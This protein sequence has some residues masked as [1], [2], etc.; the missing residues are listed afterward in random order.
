MSMVEEAL[1]KA[2]VSCES[3]GGRAPLRIRGPLRGGTYG[4]DGSKSSQFLTGL[5]IALARAPGDSVVRVDK[6]ASRGYVDL[7]LDIMRRFGA[8]ASRDD[9]YSRF[10]IAGESGYEGCAYEVEGDWSGGAFLLVAGALASGP[11]GMRVFGLSPG[12]ASPTAPYCKPWLW[13]ARIVL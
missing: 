12:R 9:E 5:L 4:L 8:T 10:S 1:L 3:S 13:Q 6:L 11:Q 7:S 2:G